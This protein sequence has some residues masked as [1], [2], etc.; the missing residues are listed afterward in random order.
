MNWLLAGNRWR[1][2][3]C[4][5]LSSSSRSDRSLPV[6]PLV[7]VSRGERAAVQTE[8]IQ[9]KRQGK[10]LLFFALVYMRCLHPPHCL[11]AAS[12]LQWDGCP[13][14]KK[15]KRKGGRL[16]AAETWG[17]CQ[18]RD[19]LSRKKKLSPFFSSPLCASSSSLLTLTLSTQLKSS[20][21][22]FLPKIFVY[23]CV[24]KLKII[25]SRSVTKW[26]L[27]GKGCV[28]LRFLKSLWKGSTGAVSTIKVCEPQFVQLTKF[29]L[30]CDIILEVFF[31]SF[32]FFF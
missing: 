7:P 17:Y 8:C 22:T 32:S 29:G 16:V 14:A 3:L 18:K 24:Y 11:P 2:P 27:Q 23:K 15:R 28:G 30:N 26:H 31:F 4:P 9:F 13:P 10:R 12:H 19:K 20:L 21:F 25:S 1:D 5:A 6:S